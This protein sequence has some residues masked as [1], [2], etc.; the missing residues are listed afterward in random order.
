[1]NIAYLISA[2]TD[3]PQ[4][5]RLIGA[6]HPEAEYFVHIDKKSD[7]TPFKA[8]IKAPNVHF[9]EN[10]IDVRWG[11]IIE[12]EYQIALI[13]AAVSH[14]RYFDR[15]FFLSGMDYPLWSNDKITQWL[16]SMGDK[17]ILQ[18]INMNTDYIQGQQRQLYTH[19]RPLFRL[20]NNKWN[21]RLSI[22]CRKA[23]AMLGYRKRMHFKVDGQEWDLYKGSAW[24][25]ISEELAA[26]VLQ[27]YRQHKEIYKYFRDSFGQAETLIQ[28]IA[29]N[30]SQ[31]ASRCMLTEGKY[32]GLDA[33]TPLHYIVYDPV[34]KVM[35]E[36]DL[37]AMMES[38]KMF[39]RKFRSGESLQNSHNE[40]S[41]KV[42]E[43]INQLRK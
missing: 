4:M 25:C 43:K 36:E 14:P 1:M 12:V 26:F 7:I 35:T 17:E 28:T 41:D 16:K 27:T 15:I 39:A 11:T 31:W 37:P 22:L 3:A 33:L 24:W 19:S 2:H 20:F 40:A 34:I 18:G 38:G 30:S 6:L 32:P 42:I 23:L 13:E 29:F 8:L 5:E 10:R 9:I 21:Q